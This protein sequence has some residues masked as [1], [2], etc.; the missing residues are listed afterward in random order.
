MKYPITT[1]FVALL[2]AGCAHEKPFEVTGQVSTSEMREDYTPESLPPGQ[3]ESAPQPKRSVTP[4]PTFPSAQRGATPPPARNYTPAPVR[5]ETPTAPAQSAQLTAPKT[6]TPKVTITPETG[7]QGKIVSVNANLRFV[8]L[9]FPIGRMAAVDQR[10]SVYRDGQK[11]GEL[12]VTG[13]Q[14]DDNIIADITNGEAQA[15]DEVR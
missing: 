7:L 8:V 1:V 11:V 14:Q 2:F 13:P 9:N 5:S 12:K 4:Q 15:G 3:V 6:E 10:F